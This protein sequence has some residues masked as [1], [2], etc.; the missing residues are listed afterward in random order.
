MPYAL[1]REAAQ[2]KRLEFAIENGEGIANRKRAA[3]ASLKF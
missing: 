1:G 2:Q 3:T